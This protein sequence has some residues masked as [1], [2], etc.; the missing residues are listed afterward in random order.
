MANSKSR[1][2]FA[3]SRRTVWLQRRC[4]SKDTVHGIRFASPGCAVEWCRVLVTCYNTG[5][6]NTS[7]ITEADILSEVVGPNQPGINPEFAQ[8]I[9]D[10][11]F[12]DRANKQ[13]RKLLNKNNKGT[14][15]ESE[16]ATL[17]KYL[18]VGQFLDLMQA[19]A[20][21]SLEKSGAPE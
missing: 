16:R 4:T 6:E 20:K 8:A 1:S 15:N 19:K 5:M 18:R 12:T 10:L 14:I 2:C 11:H 21:L 13:I 3:G 17:D 7:T 9:L